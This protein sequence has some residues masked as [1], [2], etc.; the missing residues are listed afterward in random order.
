MKLCFIPVVLLCPLIVLGQG[1]LVPPGPPAPG[2]KTLDQMEPRI[3]LAGGTS[4][5]TISAPGSYFLTGDLT[6]ATGNG[7]VISADNVTLDL[8]GFTISSTASSVNGSGILLTNE[9]SGVELRNGHIQGTLTY[10]GNTFSGGSF[11]NGI[12]AFSSSTNGRITGI[13]VNGVHNGISVPCQVDACE[14]QNCRFNGIIAS[15]VTHCSARDCGG[16]GIVAS[17]ASD[18]YASGNSSPSTLQATNAT[19]CFAAN[20]GSGAGINSNTVQGCFGQS[21]SGT[22]ITALVAQNSYGFSNSGIAINADAVANCRGEST[23][24]NGI[25][26]KTVTN[27]YGYSTLNRGISCDI[28]TASYGVC[29]SGGSFGINATH[30]AAQQLRPQRYRIRA[31]RLH[32]QF[33]S[34]REQQRPFPERELQIQ[35]AVIQRGLALVAAA[36]LLGSFAKAAEPFE[37][38]IEAVMNR[39]EQATKLLYTIGPETMRV[40]VVDPKTP[41]PV[42]LV[43]L[44]T[45]LLTLVL[46]HNQSFQRVPSGSSIGKAAASP[47]MPPGLRQAGP[48]PALPPMPAMPERAPALKATGKKEKIL[49]YACEQYE[50]SEGGET[51]EIWATPA[52]IPFQNYLRDAAPHFGPH[53]IE[54]Q[55]AAPLHAR[56]LF[57][58]RAI[59]HDET[60]NERFRFEVKSI[61]PG[62]IT[63]QGVFEPP[64]DYIE[65]PRPVQ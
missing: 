25:R 60:P 47:A 16:I 42:D 62:P 21:E 64:P 12:S 26:A 9:R 41:A 22:G 55:W 34:R 45:G 6:V 59:L 14:V 48:M 53:T 56:K 49:G 61:K 13:T 28:V 5:I 27:S 31:R 38:R 19:N 35:H 52:L 65:A 8:N 4:T 2:M 1:D 29:V 63:D 18:C 7:I 23:G 11:N 40:E 3:P 58:L 54:E 50:I 36:S 39:G 32:R 24:S 43:N 15:V 46:P 57:P 17:T 33:L 20:S 30:I 37:G 44:K 10:N 51:M